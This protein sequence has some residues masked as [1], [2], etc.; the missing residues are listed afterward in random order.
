MPI[1]KEETSSHFHPIPEAKVIPH[2]LELAMD[3]T[4]VHQM[5]ECTTSPVSSP[6]VTSEIH[7]CAQC[8][9][10]Q[11]P[12]WRNGPK[13]PRTLCNAC[14]IRLHRRLNKLKLGTT[15]RRRKRATKSASCKTVVPSRHY[16]RPKPQSSSLTGITRPR[17]QRLRSRRLRELGSGLTRSRSFRCEDFTAAIDLLSL[18]KERY[19]L[20]GRRLE[21]LPNRYECLTREMGVTDGD[22]LG[23][24]KMPLSRTD[25]KK[26]RFQKDFVNAQWE[27]QTADAGKQNLG[28]ILAEFSEETARKRSQYLE[29]CSKLE[30]FLTQQFN[31]QTHT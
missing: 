20:I 18:S 12:Q 30:A 7:C 3:L 15:Q 31:A 4:D 25:V 9:T 13:G 16:L 21:K 19:R 14:G 22:L 2:D 17:S 6:A 29:A 27:V 28:E 24:S 8:G 10:T 1:L 26:K 11:T 23:C 5:V